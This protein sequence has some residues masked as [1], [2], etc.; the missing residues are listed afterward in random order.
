MDR[1]FND[2]EHNPEQFQFDDDE[3]GTDYEEIEEE[4]V[5]YI[6]KR[7]LLDVMHM[8]LAHSELNHTLLSKAIGI[9]EKSIFW[10]FRSASYKM[11]QIE[12]IYNRLLLITGA[13]AEEESEE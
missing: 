9:A 6:D 3:F 5:A 7:D 12:L 10:C 11:D 2:D 4:A 8:D 1:F 13:I